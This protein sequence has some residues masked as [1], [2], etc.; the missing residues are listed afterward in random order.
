MQRA[1]AADI[2]GIARQDGYRNLREDGLIKAWREL[3][4][5]DEVLRVTGLDQ[6]E[7]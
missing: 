4:G 3:A 1:T 6:N 7:E 5:V 2:A